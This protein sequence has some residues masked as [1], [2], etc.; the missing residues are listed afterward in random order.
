M[1][2]IGDGV[3]MYLYRNGRWTPSKLV[4]DQGTSTTEDD[5]IVDI[6][7]IPVLVQTEVTKQMESHD[8]DVSDVHHTS[9]ADTNEYPELT[10]F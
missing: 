9:S 1:K 8:E 4:S 3:S 2:P 7:N 6:S 5:T 10:I